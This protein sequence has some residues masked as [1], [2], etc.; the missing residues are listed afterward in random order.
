MSQLLV[1]SRQFPQSAE[2]S[3]SISGMR[4]EPQRLRTTFA[5]IYVLKV[6]SRAPLLCSFRKHIRRKLGAS[7]SDF[8]TACAHLA[9]VGDGER[10]ASATRN[11]LHPGFQASRL[12]IGVMSSNFRSEP[13]Q[14]FDFP[15][16]GMDNGC[17]RA[18]ITCH[19]IPYPFRRVGAAA[20]RWKRGK[21]LL[22]GE[23]FSEHA[24]SFR[25]LRK[26]KMW[27][28]RHM[29]SRSTF[30]RLLYLRTREPAISLLVTYVS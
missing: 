7:T 24:L 26:I 9:A 3:H 18:L 13:T 27:V 5:S 4:G 15:V 16:R 6:T 2:R 28:R 21:L 8:N 30:I 1:F 29:H 22:G 25:P 17:E 11:S 20:R 23:P 10:K 14:A 19:V 12:P